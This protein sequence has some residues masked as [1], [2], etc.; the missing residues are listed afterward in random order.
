MKVLKA[1][2]KEILFEVTCP[3]EFSPEVLNS[4]KWTEALR[5]MRFYLGR[6]VCNEEDAVKLLLGSYP[7]WVVYSADKND[8]LSAPTEP[9]VRLTP[10]PQMDLEQLRRVYISTNDSY[11]DSIG[12]PL[13]PAESAE[14]ESVLSEFLPSAKFS[15]FKNN[16]VV[17]ALLVVVKWKDCFD[18]PVDW[19]PWVWI[20]RSLLPGERAFVRSKWKEW[21]R[22]IVEDRVQCIVEGENMR[23]R[24]FFRGMGF[25]PEC[26]VISKK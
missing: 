23:S 26:L 9:P 1:A 6:R 14:R 25:H 3:S 18:K 4:L 20:D 24:K 8:F 22:G 17:M 7:T 21:L 5:V 15:A 16:G 19:V 10:A 13:S 12:K 11:H 2:E